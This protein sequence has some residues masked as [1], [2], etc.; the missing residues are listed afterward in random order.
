MSTP[1][2]RRR[3]RADLGAF[4]QHRHIVA[5]LL[6][7]IPGDAATGSDQARRFPATRL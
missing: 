1:A 2:P 5:I 6:D 4:S 7:R 3:A